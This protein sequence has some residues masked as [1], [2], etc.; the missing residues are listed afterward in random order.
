[1]ES[2]LKRKM[3]IVSVQLVAE[4]TSLRRNLYKTETDNFHDTQLVKILITYT[5]NTF[6]YKFVGYNVEV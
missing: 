1:M 6:K 4:L 3:S 5:R 2:S